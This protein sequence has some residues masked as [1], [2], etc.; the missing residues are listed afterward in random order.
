[1]ILTVAYTLGIMII[2]VGIAT[3]IHLIQLVKIHLEILY[4]VFVVLES[5]CSTELH[6]RCRNLPPCFFLV[7]AFLV[8]QESAEKKHNIKNKTI[9]IQKGR[10]C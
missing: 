5:Y 9:N 4:L 7:L 10:T 1:M 6:Q 2:L 8:L 3:L